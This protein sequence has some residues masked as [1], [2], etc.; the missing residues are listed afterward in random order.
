MKPFSHRGAALRVSAR[1]YGVITRAVA[2]TPAELDALIPRSPPLLASLVPLRVP[3]WAPP[4]ARRMADAAF[5]VGDVGPMAAVAGATAWAAAEAALQHGHSSV[6]VDNGGDVALCGEAAFFVGLHAGSRSPIGDR[7]A[8]RCESGGRLLAVCASSSRLGHSFSAGDCDLAVVVARDGALADAAATSAAN[9]VRCAT[10]IPA[11][12]ERVAAIRGV[13]GVFLA[14]D[15]RT[16]MMG[17]EMPDLV[18]N[19][20]PDLRLRIAGAAR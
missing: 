16:G 4:V 12:L 20:D 5:C 14:R 10:D 11:T 9:Q 3:E 18:R 7:L 8:L 2:D 1:A 15:D 17:A 6:L 19:S 13:L